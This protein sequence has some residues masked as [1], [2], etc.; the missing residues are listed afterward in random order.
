[1]SMWETVYW[2]FAHAIEFLLGALFL[3]FLGVLLL[4]FIGI[5]VWTVKEWCGGS[6][7]G[8]RYGRRKEEEETE[9]EYGSADE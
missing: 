5:V 9:E 6:K 3:V 1:M 7:N 2:I 4:V 8:W